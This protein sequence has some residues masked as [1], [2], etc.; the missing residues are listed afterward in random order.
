MFMFS[1][2]ARFSFPFRITDL[3]SDLV[4]KLMKFAQQLVSRGDL[5][6]AKTLRSKILERYNARKNFFNPP[7]TLPSLGVSLRY[8]IDFV[9]A[10]RLC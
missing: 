7:S 6:H 10:P 1:D 5:V 2:R 8:I 9:P 4:K 3:T